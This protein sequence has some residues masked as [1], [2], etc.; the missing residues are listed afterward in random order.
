MMKHKWANTLVIRRYSNTLKQSCY[1]DLKW[2]INQLNVKH[3]WKTNESLPELTYLPTGQKILFRGLDDPLKITSITVDTGILSW[4]WF[5]EAYELESEDKFRTVVESIRGSFDSP[6]FF[7]QITI[8]F[9]PW[10]E[11]HWLKRV[12]FDKETQEEDTFAIT[13]TFRVNEWL[14]DQDRKRYTSLY[15]TNPRRAKIVCDGE[16]GVAE[17][18]VYENFVVEEF[19]H[20]VLQ[21]YGVPHKHGLDFGY[22][23]DP[24]AFVT[25]F[26][27]ERE[28]KLF[29]FD[30]HYETG[31]LNS[32]IADMLKKKG[33]AKEKITADSA[34]PKSIDELKQLGIPRINLR[35]KVQI[36]CEPVSKKYKIIRLLFILD[37]FISSKKSTIMFMR[38]IKKEIP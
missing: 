11:R 15:R 22:K 18:L 25:I 30:E 16:W 9:N 8:T 27:D 7:K 35:R 26:V 3:L 14:D 6:D 31:M 33:V 32:K 21:R 5:E 10:S 2:A 24:T 28:K 12:F 23:H 1:T 19:D 37:V 38:R 36:V 4:A 17:G 29:I 34:E 20:Q 13:T